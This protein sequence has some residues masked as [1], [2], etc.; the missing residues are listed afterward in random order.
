MRRPTELKPIEEYRPKG[1]K[2][3]K[4]ASDEHEKTGKQNNGPLSPIMEE[5]RSQMLP[6]EED[7]ETSNFTSSKY[8]TPRTTTEPPLISPRQSISQGH[9]ASIPN[10]SKEWDESMVF[11]TD[12]ALCIYHDINGNRRVILPPGDSSVPGF[13]RYVSEEHST[14]NRVAYEREPATLTWNRALNTIFQN[15]Y[16]DQE[17][18]EAL[19]ER[20]RESKRPNGEGDEIYMNAID[21]GLVPNF[22]YPIPGSAFYDRYAADQSRNEEEVDER[23]TEEEEMEYSSE[24]WPL[25]SDHRGR[26][27]STCNNDDLY[28]DPTDTPPTSTMPDPHALPSGLPTAGE[29]QAYRVLLNPSH[30]SPSCSATKLRH[31]EGTIATQAKLIRKL[32]TIVDVLRETNEDLVERRVPDMAM[33]LDQKNM[34]IADLEVMTSALYEEVIDLRAA[35]DF[36]H[37]VLGECWAR[38]WEMWRTVEDIKHRKKRHKGLFKEIF[39]SRNGKAHP[40]LGEEGDIFVGGAEPSGSQGALSHM[41]GWPSFHKRNTNP[42]L[43]SN[44]SKASLSKTEIDTLEAMAE[45]NL[46]ILREDVTDMLALIQEYTEYGTELWDAESE[47]NF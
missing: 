21:V 15:E 39:N 4:K 40:G 8:F 31:H 9:L 11:P 23:N 19:R 22:S 26:T 3:N 37:K 2:G 29:L 45:Q 34:N 28:E 20:A 24:E 18:K 7:R 36:G 42:T 6:S 35:V 12:K 14:P 33:K 16:V 30:S 27:S 10:S 25:P 46:R 44:I 38:E 43:R 41:L 5:R 1:Y 47:L 13:R 32:H 17:M